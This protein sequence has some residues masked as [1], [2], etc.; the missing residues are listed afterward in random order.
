MIWFFMNCSLRA[1][2]VNYRS[3]CLGEIIIRRRIE[4]KTVMKTTKVVGDGCVK[5]KLST[6]L[7]GQLE[8]RKDDILR[9]IQEG[10][11]PFDRVMSELQAVAEGRVE[12]L[13]PENKVTLS[14]DLDHWVTFYREYFFFRPDFSGLK[15]P[16]RTD[17]QK[18]EFTRLLVIAKDIT[19]NHVYRTCQKQFIC[20]S[21][22]D[23]L[24][25]AVPTNERDP[26]NGL[27]A[28]WVRD[29]VEADKVHKNKSADMIKQ[30]NL[31]TET[32]L[33]RM[34]HELV[35]FSETGKHLD[36]KN[37]TLCSGSHYSGGD[38]PRA[39]W[40]DDLFRVGWDVTDYRDD[41]LRS[42]EVVS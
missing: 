30:A 2:V 34:I 4:R 14:T 15:I 36:V 27:Y 24:D 26:K 8:I 19:N 1:G 33:E 12:I 11:L 23:N 7:R 28:I 35:F 16:E 39:R 3:E 25:E 22:A 42:R 18:K 17:E 20:L 5:G 40:Y 13:L 10:T 21:Y 29:T 41:D 37:A 31:T 32:L 38:V 6:D 9:R